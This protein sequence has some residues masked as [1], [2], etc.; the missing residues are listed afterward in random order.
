[1]PVPAAWNAPLRPPAP[2]SGKACP[3]TAA[4]HPGVLDAGTRQLVTDIR[5]RFPAADCVRRR[6]A[7]TVR[8]FPLSG[9][10]H[11]AAGFASTTPF[12]VARAI[13]AR[14]LLVAVASVN[15]AG[16]RPGRRGSA[17]WHL[18]GGR[19]V[20]PPRRPGNWAA[21]C[22]T[23]GDLSGRCARSGLR[24][25]VFLPQECDCGAGRPRTRAGP[26]G[27]DVRS[28]AVRGAIKGVVRA[29]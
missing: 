9:L 7:A 26:C 12:H 21:A 2:R 22:C 29:S 10:R 14:L 25:R 5:R 17:S 28:P 18:T 23:A 27:A 20:R 16:R 8:T 4:W 3:G 15:A 13:A 19:A 24:R 6:M 1:V 11:R